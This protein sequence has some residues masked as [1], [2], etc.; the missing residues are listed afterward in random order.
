[1]SAEQTQFKCGYCGFLINSYC[2]NYLDHECFRRLISQNQDRTLDLCANEQNILTLEL[3]SGLPISQNVAAPVASAKLNDELLISLVY[4]RKPLWDFRTPLQARQGNK[5]EQLWEEVANL[6]GVKKRWRQLRDDY[7]R[8]KKK[9]TAY[10]PSGAGAA[11]V[12]PRPT[13]KYYDLMKFL[14]ETD[15]DTM[16]I[17]NVSLPCLSPSSMSR[18]CQSTEVPMA[19]N[20]STPFKSPTSVAPSST[21]GNKRRRGSVS[22]EQDVGIQNE[23]LRELRKPEKEPDG[24]DGFLVLLGE[25]LRRLPLKNRN[26]LQIK[27]LQMLEEEEINLQTN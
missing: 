11:D 6:L 20:V 18:E 25:G 13:F 19:T 24:V 27:F 5:V 26:H 12:P 3:P 22:G 10:V 2:E 4:A 16:T 17:S 7:M 8:A 1:M 23:V 15:E 9:V 14:E 21:L